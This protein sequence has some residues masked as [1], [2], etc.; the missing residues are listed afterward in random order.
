MRVSAQECP[1][2]S[3]AFLDEELR[4]LG[5]TRFSEEYGLAFVDSEESAF[6]TTII[7][8]AFIAEVLPL[9]I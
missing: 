2:I 3:H 8:T 7:H 9:W 6:P 4:E 1:R 5:A